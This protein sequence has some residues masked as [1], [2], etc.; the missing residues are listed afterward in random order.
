MTARNLEAPPGVEAI[1]IVF[2]RYL[3]RVPN[4]GTTERRDDMRTNGPGGVLTRVAVFGTGIEFNESS[5]R[6]QDA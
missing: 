5:R 2:P 1:R 6:N 3:P 4:S